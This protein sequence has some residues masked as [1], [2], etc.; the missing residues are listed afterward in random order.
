ME[1]AVRMSEESSGGVERD[2]PSVTRTHLAKS[3]ATLSLK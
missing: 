2:S 3:I 1:L